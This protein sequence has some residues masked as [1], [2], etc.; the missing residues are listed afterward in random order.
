VDFFDLKTAYVLMGVHYFTMPATVWLALRHKRSPSA[1]A[2][3]SSGVLFGLGLL[4]MSR[5]THW[6]D[7]ITYDLANLAVCMGQL[8]GLQTLRLELGRPWARLTL[9]ALLGCFALLYEFAV[10]A[11]PTHKLQYLL[12]LA[13]LVL[14]FSCFAFF[15]SRLG[16]EQ[17][18]QSGYWL[19]GI[20]LPVVMVAVKHWFDV[21]FNLAPHGSLHSNAGTVGIALMGNLVAMIGSTSFLDMHVERAQRQAQTSPSRQTPAPAPTSAKPNARLGRQIAQLERER[22]MGMVARSM[23]HELSQ[24]LTSLQLIAEHAQLDA[25]QRPQDHDSLRTHIAQILLHARQTAQVLK[26]VRAFTAQPEVPHERL[27]VLALNTQVLALLQDR[28]RCDHIALDLHL[29]AGP[30]WVM[31]HETQLGVLLVNLYRQAIEACTQSSA[32]RRIVVDMATAHARV[33]L[34]I[35]HSGPSL[36]P[37]ALKLANQTHGIFSPQAMEGQAIGLLMSRKIAAEH[38]GHLTVCN[39]PAGGTVTEL[40]LPQ[41]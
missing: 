30:V 33:Q 37:E 12:S 1:G 34:K 39:A 3:S 19:S 16:R 9:L 7:W 27:D 15:A 38:Q 32:Q 13:W 31:G 20:C 11:D 10:L 23:A 2:W 41:A 40:D 14:Y 21:L 22:G 17:G 8:A 26:R 6:P 24:P 28:L 29:P 18:L 5:R 4:L 35:H 36:S 25:A